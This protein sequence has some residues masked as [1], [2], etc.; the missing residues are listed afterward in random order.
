MCASYAFGATADIDLT[1]VFSHAVLPS[2]LHTSS[3]FSRNAEASALDALGN[4][5]TTIDGKSCENQTV[6]SSL[7]PSTSCIAS[8]CA[9]SISAHVASSRVTALIVCTGRLVCCTWKSARS[10]ASPDTTLSMYLASWAWLLASVL[11]L[12]P[13]SVDSD[14]VTM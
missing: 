4:D 5:T 12:Q 13:S 1:P 2:P 8:N 10:N 7:P 11:P 6:E 14:L 9:W 3:R